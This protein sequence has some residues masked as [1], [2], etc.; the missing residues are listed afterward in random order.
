[1]EEIKGTG[2]FIS[3]LQK[4][5][6]LITVLLVVTTTHA[7]LRSTLITWKDWSGDDEETSVWCIRAQHPRHLQLNL[8]GHVHRNNMHA[9]VAWT[10]RSNRGGYRL[11]IRRRSELIALPS[12]AM[13]RGV[14]DLSATLNR[15]VITLVIKKKLRVESRQTRL[16]KCVTNLMVALD[17]GSL[18]NIVPGQIALPDVTAAN[19][20]SLGHRAME[21]F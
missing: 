15:R 13:Y 17:Y 9:D 2:F 5:C 21:N 8:D 11:T 10:Y 19:A 6:H 4:P 20:V 12:A 14:F 18:T 1:M 16:T 7:M 3:W